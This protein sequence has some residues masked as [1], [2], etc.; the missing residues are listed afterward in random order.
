VNGASPARPRSVG[1]EAIVALVA[2][3]SGTSGCWSVKAAELR[4]SLGL[5]PLDFYRDMY[6]AA[7]AERSVLDLGDITGAFSS[8]APE[9]FLAALEVFC[10]AEAEPRLARAGIFFPHASR[11]DVLE[12]FVGTL[13]DEVAAHTLDSDAFAAML[14][15]LR[16]FEAARTAYLGEHFALDRI[17][18]AAVERYCATRDFDIPVLACA[19]VRGLIAFF[20]RRHVLDEAA[21][22]AGV[23]A[24][25]RRI[26]FEHGYAP[27]EQ[28]AAPEEP[29]DPFS[30]ALRTLGVDGLPLSRALLR[31]R[32]RT[33]M[34]RYH[35][36]VNPRGL[37]KAQEINAAYSQVLSILAG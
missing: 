20:F 12:T 37:Q 2:D 24:R 35:P 7:V 19:N 33:L 9:V 4:D 13:A 17:T 10:G 27:R 36:D 3:R 6:A 1:L 22:F 5:T 25:L 30:A 34:K 14:R 15:G 11:V 26:A 32:Y 23:S 29:R 31:E 8:E 18:E 21:L 16:R 28:P